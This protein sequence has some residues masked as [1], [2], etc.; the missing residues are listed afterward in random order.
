MVYHKTPNRRKISTNYLLTPE[1]K[2]ILEYLKDK[3]IC[4]DTQ[5]QLI[6]AVKEILE[7]KTELRVKQEKEYE[8]FDWYGWENSYDKI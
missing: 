2:G 4:N 3:Y 6:A 8:R 7:L 5:D 1:E